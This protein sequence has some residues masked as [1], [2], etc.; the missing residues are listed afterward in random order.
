M[1]VMVLG[2]RRVGGDM[3]VV[4]EVVGERREADW[5]ARTVKPRAGREAGMSEHAVGVLL[6]KRAEPPRPPIVD[7]GEFGELVEGLGYESVWTSEGWG[8]DAF[9]ELA[10]IAQHT[11]RVRLG[12]AIANIFTRT[13]AGLAMAAASLA[14]VSDG[15]AVLGLGAGHPGLVEDLHDLPYERPIGRMYET[16]SLVKAFLQGEDETVEYSR[17]VFEVSGFPP[18]G[19]DVPV[20]TAA[21]GETNRRICGRVSDGWIPYNIPLSDIGAAFETVAEAA[22]EYGR[23]PDAIAVTPYVAAAVSDD[24]EAACRVVR[25]NVA[26]YVGGFTD[27]SYRNA[28]ATRFPAETDAIADAWRAGDEA[29]AA[30]AVT[31]EMVDELGIAG[32][33][34]EARER[35]R[36]LCAQP[37]VDVPLVAVPHAASPELADRTVRELA[38]EKL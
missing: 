33:P 32:I 26:S 12:T 13:P 4:P 31:D 20:Y 19:V 35:L 28:V 7:V 22:R 37:V 38:P 23:D 36:T 6:P 15:R 3:T 18:L 16:V 2:G 17:K 30:A 14:R 8:S 29:A 5:E 25:E 24:G 10:A 34:E 11:E 21:L 9:V 27:E 1:V